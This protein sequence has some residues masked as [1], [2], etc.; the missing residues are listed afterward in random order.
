MP[1]K[2]SVR[3]KLQNT[4]EFILCW[5]SVMGVGTPFSVLYM[6]SETPLGKTNFLHCKQWFDDSFLLSDRS[7]CPLP[8]LSSGT[9]SGL[10]LCRSCARCTVSESPCVSVSLCSEDTVI[11]FLC[12]FLSSHL[13]FYIAHWALKG[14]VWWRHPISDW[15]IHS[16]WHSAHCPV[17]DC[18]PLN[19]NG[20]HRFIC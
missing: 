12:L 5:P 3:Q 7:S 9:T 18:G 10:N 13:L 2:T 14:G 15:V 1:K 16:H 6:P 11:Y 4:I 19:E 17:M 8:P 20:L